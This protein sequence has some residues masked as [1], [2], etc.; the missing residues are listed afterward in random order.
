MLHDDDPPEPQ[1]DEQDEQQ[2]DPI[3]GYT[4][5]V[6]VPRQARR[7]EVAE[8]QE[9][10]SQL[11]AATLDESGLSAGTVARL[12]SPPH[13]VP[14]ITDPERAGIRMFL[15]RGDASEDNYTD[16]RAAM[17]ELHPEDEK[18]VPTYEQAKRLVSNVTGIDALV[19]H[20]CVNSCLAFTG[21]F[22][23]A[24][25]CP[26]CKEPRYDQLDTTNGRQI[27]R[28][29]FH[30]YPLGPQLQAMYAS[31]EN[32]RLMRHRAERT[33][34]IRA[35]L[36]ADPDS[37]EVLDDIYWG[38][39]YLAAVNDHVIEE[40]DIVLMF[41]LDGAQLYESKA[42][43]TW[44]Y[45]W[46]LFDLP[47]TSRYRKRFVLPGGV[48]GG[49]KKPKNVDSFLFPGLHHVAA[50]QREGLEIWDAAR[51][52]QFTS[53]LFLYL[54]TAD[55]PGMAYL[56]GLVG[57]QGARGCRLYCGLLG[58]FKPSAS[59][60]Y[61]AL[62]RSHDNPH[63]GSDHPDADPTGDPEPSAI[64]STRY[65]QNLQYV[66]SSRSHAEYQRRRLET[67]IAKPSIFSGLPRT[68]SLPGCFGADLM[69]L[70]TLNLTDL[71]VSHLRGT[72]QCDPTDDRAS[73]DWAVLGDPQVWRAHGRLVQDATR[74]LP[75]SFD[76][77]PRNP[78]EKISSGYKAWEF[79]LYVYGLLP[80]LLRGV[81][82]A[83]YYFHF[84]K[85]VYGIRIM[86]QHSIPLVQVSA[87][88]VALVE[89]AMEYEELYY[90]RRADRLHFVR[91]SVH[92]LIHI[93]P[94]ALRL[95]PGSLYTQWTLE[96]FIGNITREIKQHSTPYANVS[97]RALRR[98]R[99]NALQAAIT[100]FAPDE[101]P[102]LSSVDL[103]DRYRLLRARERG[104]V[105]LT[106]VIEQNALF[107]CLHA[108][109][110]V[111]EP[112]YKPAVQRWARLRLPNGQIA[113][114]LWK[115][116]ITESRGRECRRAR[117]VK[118]RMFPYSLVHCT[119]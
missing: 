89:Y 60:Y 78:A 67:G 44:F 58:R 86:L 27:P 119:R 101:E 53:K 84:C 26:I 55:G 12:R 71:L 41:S 35:Q 100:A 59:T 9:F 85:L 7:R 10:I 14:T 105:K 42:S 28:R 113:R 61:P 46:V 102:P 90:A 1:P 114:S 43:D 2:A 51:E 104:S 37:A 96:N 52:V 57:H 3:Y 25:T 66:I 48:I 77:P 32:A 15:A 74:Y 110:I 65:T 6:D 63:D 40:D 20:M 38:N 107:E 92:A 99:I 30:T 22:A 82:P 54:A 69:H 95:G 94:E 118:V 116:G 33:E 19:H 21:P 76:R 23:Q 56:S 16:N 39:D 80:G 111:I 62:Y 112:G 108:H 115:E 83:P 8:V 18:T 68:L 88:H 5:D 81:L 64:V 13:R 4:E 29:T 31:P 49:P 70:V 97:E 72:I 24:D 79:L 109:D 36:A 45:I 91:Q 117:M 93:A 34:E 47:P 87:A 98:T 106:T 73:W 11:R 17:V 75:G 103:G 50:L